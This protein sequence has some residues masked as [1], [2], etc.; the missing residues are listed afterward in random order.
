MSE[1]SG[2][3]L[4]DWGVERFGA[5]WLLAF[6]GALILLTPLSAI[7]TH[8]R[9]TSI[10]YVLASFLVLLALGWTGVVMVAIF[11]RR[12]SPVAKIV[13]LLAAGG[14]L[15]PLLWAP[16]LG[17]I[18]AAWLTGAAIEYSQVY[19]QFRIHVGQ[20]LFPLVSVLTRSDLVD[21]GWN[22][23]QAVATI[24]G[25]VAAVIQLWPSFVASFRGAE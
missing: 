2:D 16:V 17:A 21:L 19:A 4:L 23:F 13:F 22:A 25:F 14:L 10:D 3:V 18:V 6:L 7:A 12:A 8:A 15:L 20:L 24:I 5:G 11:I 1:S 9:Y